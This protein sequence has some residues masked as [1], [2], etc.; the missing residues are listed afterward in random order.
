MGVIM[1]IKIF[2]IAFLIVSYL[3]SFLIH[4]FYTDKS[5]ILNICVALGTIMIVLIYFYFTYIYYKKMEVKKSDIIFPFIISLLFDISINLF[6]CFIKND[7]SVISI[8]SI[9]GA[10]LIFITVR[11]LSLKIKSKH[12]NIA[13]IIFI[14]ILIYFLA[15][16]IVGTLNLFLP[17]IIKYNSNW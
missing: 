12:Q 2:H 7:N 9:T 11:L 4:N 3:Y 5:V 6:G 15:F 14:F 1:K 17:G 13:K 8:L 16:I 10:A